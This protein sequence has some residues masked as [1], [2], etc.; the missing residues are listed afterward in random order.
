MPCCRPD[1]FRFEIIDG[2]ILGIWPDEEEL[3]ADWDPGEH[4]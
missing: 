2:V 1:P 4:A 3:F